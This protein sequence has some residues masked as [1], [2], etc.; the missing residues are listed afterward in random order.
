MIALRRTGGLRLP[1][2]SERLEVADDGTFR[3]WR[4]VSMAAPLPSP[5][6]RFAGRLPVPQ[7]NALSDAAKRAAAEGSRTW[8]V[9]PDSPVDEFEVDGAMATLGIHDPGEGA[10]EACAALV[11]P[12]LGELTA[13]PLAAIALEVTG[14]PALY[15]QGR[16]PLTLDLSHLTV[17]AVHW[18]EGQS[19]GRWTAPETDRGE[20]GAGPG[21]R[22]RLPFDHGFALEAGDRLTVQAT[23]AAFD[24]DRLVPVSLQ[25]P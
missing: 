6:G 8:L 7:L 11:R 12:L 2:F 4:S 14:G 16:E 17:R 13:S 24:G 25:T 21:W 10:W 19:Q 3:M 5:I 15:H 22:L 18:R 20:V 1:Q 23:L 9:S